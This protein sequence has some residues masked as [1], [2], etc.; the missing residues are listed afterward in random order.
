MCFVFNIHSR[1]QTNSE[2]EKSSGDFQDQLQKPCSIRSASTTSGVW[3]AQFPKKSC[4]LFCCSYENSATSPEAFVASFCS[5]IRPK[6]HVSPLFSISLFGMPIALFRAFA[7]PLAPFTGRE[8]E[9]RLCI[10]YL[11]R[12]RP[13]YKSEFCI[14]FS[15]SK[16]WIFP[17]PV[18]WY[19]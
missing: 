2:P 19:F 10:H 13:S 11:Q 12:L 15:L 3:E 14:Q 16:A 4:G 1:E 17:S 18:C 5:Y 8:S 9:A 7:I 6:V